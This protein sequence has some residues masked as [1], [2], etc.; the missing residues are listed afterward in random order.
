M[1]WRKVKCEKKLEMGQQIIRDR[2]IKLKS[3]K[4]WE[5]YRKGIG[6]ILKKKKRDNEKQWKKR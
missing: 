5:E 3:E 4:F 2:E 1:K 6:L